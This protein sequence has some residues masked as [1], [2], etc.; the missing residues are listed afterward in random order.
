MRTFVETSVKKVRAKPTASTPWGFGGASKPKSTQARFTPKTTRRKLSITKTAKPKPQPEASFSTPKP[1]YRPRVGDVTA[2]PLLV[3]SGDERGAW[4]TEYT[5]TND[6]TAPHDRTQLQHTFS[7][8]VD[9]HPGDVLVDDVSYMPPQVQPQLRHET[10][11]RALDPPQRNS[12]TSQS[13]AAKART[14]RQYPSNR[15]FVS[16]LPMRIASLV[17]GRR[18]MRPLEE[19]DL[20]DYMHREAGV[21]VDPCHVDLPWDSIRNT[22]KGFAYVLLAST[23]DMERVLDLS[24]SSFHGRMLM[25]SEA[26]S[27]ADIVSVQGAALG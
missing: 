21:R 1:L 8:D 10:Q 22:L 9:V 24:S 4:P 11:R 5:L 12:S 25:V 27:P 6:S 17:R 26:A 18:L 19:K 20:A 14:N 15:V 23:N 13:R 3:S 16:N 2:T 7:P